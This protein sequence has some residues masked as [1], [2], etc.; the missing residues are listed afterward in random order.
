MKEILNKEKQ[1]ILC[2]GEHVICKYKIK[3]TKANVE[4]KCIIY[5]EKIF[6]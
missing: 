1:A 3:E 5:I 2:G 4:K 6:L